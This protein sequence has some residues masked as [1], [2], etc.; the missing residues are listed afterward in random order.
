M[1]NNEW[2]LFA[3][4]E[5]IGTQKSFIDQKRFSILTIS[6]AVQRNR[7]Y[8]ELTLFVPILVMTLL[9]PIGLILP[10]EFSFNRPN[11]TFGFSRCRRENGSTDNRFID[12]D[13]LCSSFADKHTRIWFVRKHAHDSCVFHHYYTDDLLLSVVN[14]TNTVSVSCQRVRV[15]E[16][17]QNGSQVQHCD[18]QN[19]QRFNT[20]TMDCWATSNC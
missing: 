5:D 17:F 7:P 2:R 19:S 9:S 10:G 20:P 6:L 11:K 18:N 13:Y 12:D 3:Y 1:N 14:F 15:E 8:Y 4:K 16:L